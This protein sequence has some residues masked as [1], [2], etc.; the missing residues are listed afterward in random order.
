MDKAFANNTYHI[1]FTYDPI[2][3]DP[4]SAYGEF[5]AEAQEQL[6]TL[7]ELVT[8]RHNLKGGTMKL[9]GYNEAATT[10][11]IND[12]YKDISQLGQG[13]KEAA[14]RIMG[15]N[16]IRKI[17]LNTIGHSAILSTSAFLC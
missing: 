2:K 3:L 8:K 11:E 9:A 10:R 15:Y 4:K 14:D 5:D 1:T 13:Y 6:K 17:P 12:L 16:K 7:Q